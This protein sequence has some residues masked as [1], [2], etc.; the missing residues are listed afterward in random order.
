MPAKDY[1][2]QKL[3][4]AEYQRK[5]KEEANEIGDIPPVVNPQRRKEAEKD[6]AL[7]G[8]NYCMAKDGGGLLN[9][10]ASGRM[11]EYARALQAMIDGA[12]NLH[13]RCARGA[14]KTT[15]VSIA[16]LYGLATGK[17]KFAVLFSA[18]A[19]QSSGILRNIWTVLSSNRVFAEDYP[20]IAYPIA[21]TNGIKQRY[22]TQTHKGTRT[23]MKETA[24]EIILPFIEGSPS[25]GGMVR[26]A[27]AGGSVRGMVMGATRPDFVLGDDLQTRAIAGSPHR[28]GKL[29][30]WTNGD[31]RGLQGSTLARVVITSTPIQK[32]D[33]SERFADVTRHPEFRQISFPLIFSEAKE[34]DL[35][36]KYDEIYKRCLRMGESDFK[37]AT[38]FYKANRAKMDKGVEVLDEL[39]YDSRLELSAYQHARN[40][41]VA[42]GT[43]AFEA[44]YQLKPK[45]TQSELE[46]TAKTVMGATNGVEHGILP[47]GILKIC[48]G[49]DVNAADGLSYVLVG[50]G[51][52]SKAAV[53]DYGRIAGESGRLVPKNASKSITAKIVAAALFKTIQKIWKI[54]FSSPSGA[55]HRP[56]AIWIDRGFLPDVIGG[57]VQIA[58][59][60]GIPAEA[61]KGFDSK[62]F[63]AYSR[64]V[65]ARFGDVDLRESDGRQ[66]YGINADVSKEMVQAGFLAPPLT[67]GSLSLYGL[68]GYEH[69][70]FAEEIVS[71]HLLEKFQGQRGSVYNWTHTPGAR[72][73]YLDATGYA[74]A[75]GARYGF[76][77]GVDA[78]VYSAASESM[79]TKTSSNT[80][81]AKEPEQPTRRKASIKNVANPKLVVHSGRGGIRRGRIKLR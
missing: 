43:A 71:E 81:S 27:G 3:Y 68:D 65:V 14:G 12:G 41:R 63:T 47:E 75:A 73:H 6:L 70:E 69:A 62:Y 39:Q 40:L 18:S 29:E 56:G 33:Y 17:I 9:H 79:E 1:N 58:K 67:P 74:M 76:Y 60:K 53:L 42:M 80:D 5:K 15:W 36:K 50:F 23:R 37:K 19:T 77:G 20:E 21:M 2:A 44:E 45:K 78:E 28:V 16:I 8:A 26:A 4:V 49:I 48:C 64:S 72:N 25:S 32:D 7:W 13:V 59:K 61:V 57:V 11:A 55:T 66:F 46:I 24:T 30:E 38:E 51:K 54:Q 22:G 10:V 35:W 34:A 52:N 31:V